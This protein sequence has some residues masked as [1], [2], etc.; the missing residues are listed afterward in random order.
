MEWKSKERTQKGREREKEKERKKKINNLD[1]QVC[2]VAF[3]KEKEALQDLPDELDCISF[4]RHHVIIHKSL[5]VTSGGTKNCKTKQISNM[6][7]VPV[8]VIYLFFFF[9]KGYLQLLVS[10]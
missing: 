9:S 2:H 8:R 1:I 6:F 4:I 3:V 5:K 10:C 7:D